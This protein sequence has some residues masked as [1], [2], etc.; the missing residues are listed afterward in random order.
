MLSQRLKEYRK[1]NK[2]TQVTFSKKIGISRSY[3]ADME[4]G[5]KIANIKTLNKIAM[6][7]DLSLSYWADVTLENNYTPYEV[8]N[9]YLEKLQDAGFIDNNG[10]IDSKYHSDVIDILQKE[11]N[12]KIKKDKGN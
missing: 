9:T 7:T 1:Q 12:F 4:T 2:L 10:I 3:L 5:T 8:L 6:A 11:L